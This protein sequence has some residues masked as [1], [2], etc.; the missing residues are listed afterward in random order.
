MALNR[1]ALDE[2]VERGLIGREQA[3]P[4]WLFRRKQLGASNIEHGPGAVND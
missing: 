2:A 1:G 4:L 3:E